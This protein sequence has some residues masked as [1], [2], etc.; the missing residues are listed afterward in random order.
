[1]FDDVHYQPVDDCP[2]G[3]GD[4][5]QYNGRSHHLNS[6]R[7]Y[8]ITDTKQNKLGEWLVFLKTDDYWNLQGRWVAVKTLTLVKRHERNKSKDTPMTSLPSKTFTYMV[9][10]NGC[11]INRSDS[12]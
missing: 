6:N 12:L 11:L 1:M 10:H 8:E 7:N 4:V 3:R 5:V 2:F 9:V